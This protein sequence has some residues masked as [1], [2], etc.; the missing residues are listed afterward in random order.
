MTDINQQ[1]VTSAQEWIGTPYRHQGHRKQV[2]CDCLG[3]IRGIWLEIYGVESDEPEP[4][5]KDWAE[6]AT[7]ERMLLAAQRYFGPII[8]ITDMHPGCLIHFRWRQGAAIKHAGIL[9]SPHQFIHA[10]GRV[11]VTQ[12]TLVPS[13]RR[14]IEAVFQFPEL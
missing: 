11:G 4:Y 7:Q 10:Y 5:A 8:P 3:L 2:G 13:W 6:T 9:S 1:V 12:S 14:R